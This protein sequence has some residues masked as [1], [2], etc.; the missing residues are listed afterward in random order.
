MLVLDDRLESLVTKEVEL[1]DALEGDWEERI[2]ELDSDGEEKVDSD[3]TDDIDADD[4]DSLLIKLVFGMDGVEV[5][6]GKGI[7][8]PVKIN[9]KN[10]M[11]RTLNRFG[12]CLFMIFILSIGIQKERCFL[13]RCKIA[14]SLTILRY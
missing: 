5:D 6:E 4:V 10:G 7:T 2:T 9:A 13:I 3:I 8:H 11:I 1:I 14:T 12:F